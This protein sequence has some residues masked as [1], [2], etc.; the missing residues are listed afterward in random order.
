MGVG[1]LTH[2]LLHPIGVPGFESRLHH[3][4]QLPHPL[5]DRRNTW[6]P[7]PEWETCQGVGLGFSLAGAWPCHTLEE[8]PSKWESSVSLSNAYA[9]K[10]KKNHFYLFIVL[11]AGRTS[12]WAGQSWEPKLQPRSHL[13]LALEPFP[14][15]SHRKLGWRQGSGP[16][17]RSPS[18]LGAHPSPYFLSSQT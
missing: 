9:N 16:S 5:W 18:G 2:P 3:E 17:S 6:V 1:H 12:F 15:A 11:K 14:T 4:V 7:A 13:W 8:W 10:Q